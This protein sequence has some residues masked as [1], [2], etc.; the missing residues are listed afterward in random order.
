MCEDRVPKCFNCGYCL[1]GLEATRCPEC[2]EAVDIDRILLDAEE[3][4]HRRTRELQDAA[5][6]SLIGAFVFPF[7]IPFL[8]FAIVPALA[9]IYGLVRA[10]LN[11]QWRMS[12]RSTH[13]LASV[14]EPDRHRFK[15]WLAI[16][17]VICVGAPIAVVVFLSRII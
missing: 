13:I 7:L 4:V 10:V 17:T 6:A 8:S 5:I 11:I 16:G 12:P 1:V 14:H 15:T 2:G 9:V 3:I